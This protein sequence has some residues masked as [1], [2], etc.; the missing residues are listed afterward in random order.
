M[1]ELRDAMVNY[2]NA[3]GAVDNEGPGVEQMTSALDSMGPILT[4]ISKSI[5]FPCPEGTTCVTDREALDM[6]LDTMGLISNL[7]AA[8]IQGT[9]VRNWQ[10][11]LTHALKFRIEISLLRVEFLCGANVPYIREARDAQQVGLDIFNEGDYPLALEYYADDER[12]CMMIDIYNRCIV[13][14]PSAW[15]EDEDGNSVP[16]D[17]YDLPEVCEPEE[18][19]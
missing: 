4:E 15:V 12:R 7:T 16:P 3:A 9:W 13:P 6:E 14:E 11:C 19:E 10:A 8:E 1:G 18:D 2:R 5:T 17:V